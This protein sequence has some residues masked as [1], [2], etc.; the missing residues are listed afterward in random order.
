MVTL[1]GTIANL[2]ISSN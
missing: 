2:Q 1:W